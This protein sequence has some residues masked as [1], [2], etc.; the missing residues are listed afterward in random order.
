MTP[1]RGVL[2]GR[3]SQV[4]S[5]NWSEDRKLS[6]AGTWDGTAK[7]WNAAD[8]E[9]GL[10]PVSWSPAGSRLSTGSDD[11]T[12]KVCEA[13]ST[14]AVLQWKL[15][16]T[17]LRDALAENAFKAPHAREFIKNWL[18]LLALAPAPGDTGVQTL[19]RQQIP[20][21]PLLRP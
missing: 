15:Q 7:L 6:A 18:V 16:E 3:M 21:E 20:H 1:L 19:D 14:E 5:V 4:T 17:R 11:S 8:G 10:T 2:K 12:A 13:A 9:E